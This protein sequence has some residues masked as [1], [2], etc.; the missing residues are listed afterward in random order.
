MSFLKRE[1]AL[2]KCLCF[3]VL[4]AVANALPVPCVVKL[5]EYNYRLKTEP[6]LTGVEKPRCEATGEYKGMQFRGSKA[7]CVTSQ[8]IMIDR[9]KV[10]R[11]ETGA[12]MDCQCARDEYAYIQTRR[13]GKMFF[14]EKNGNYASV[15]CT[16]SVCYCQNKMGKQVGTSTVGIWE[17]DSINC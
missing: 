17:M 3:V 4:V 8:G 9:Y 11:S 16:G 5:A 13:I 2:L 7:Y 15:G 1:E 14:C 6:Y 12:D 10:N